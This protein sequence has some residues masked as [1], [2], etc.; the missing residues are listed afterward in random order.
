M[1]RIANSPFFGTG[2]DIGTV[3]RAVVRLGIVAVRNFLVGLAAQQAFEQLAHRMPHRD[4]MWRHAVAV[5][6]GSHLI[7]DAARLPAPDEAFVAGLLHDLGQVAMAGHNPP[8]FDAVCRATPHTPGLR[9]LDRERA[10]FGMDHTQVSDVLFKRWRLPDSL[11]YAARDHHEPITAATP[12]SL[13]AVVLADALAQRL[14]FG[15][16]YDVTR[17]DRDLHAAE[18]LGLTSGQVLAIV[19]QYEE[20]VRAAEA[21]LQ[22]VAE[23]P[24]FRAD[25][26]VPRAWWTLAQPGLCVTLLE[27]AGYDVIATSLEDL[28]D[29]FSPGDTVVMRQSDQARAVA[30]TQR[31]HAVLLRRPAP[32][33][34]PRRFDAATQTW[35]LPERFSLHDVHWLRE[36]SAA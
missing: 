25:A 19:D 7:A 13:A 3:R 5:A 34:L 11:C 28:D 17:T 35:H 8:A 33:E 22:R 16:D 18:R 10:A 23:P 1:L 9:F 14:G 32:D 20:R 2:Q 30:Y 27:Q 24:R 21:M 6:A 15:M 4:T 31:G 12:L 26:A 29:R 36:S